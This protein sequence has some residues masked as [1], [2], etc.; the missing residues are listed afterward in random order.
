LIVTKKKTKTVDGKEVEIPAIE[1]GDSNG[2]TLSFENDNIETDAELQTLY[3]RLFPFSYYGYKLNA[4]GMPQI[5]CGDMIQL[6]TVKNAVYNL[7]IISH[8]L[9]YSRLP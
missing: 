1:C 3:N 6:T 7:S 5:D 8:T 2:S 9:A 4:Q